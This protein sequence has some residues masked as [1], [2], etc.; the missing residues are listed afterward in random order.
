MHFIVLLCCIDTTLVVI[1]GMIKVHVTDQE[2]SQVDHTMRHLKVVVMTGKTL[3]Y[4]NSSCHYV[5]Q[6][7]ISFHSNHTLSG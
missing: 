1:N 5:M 6:S 4:G 2:E 3:G 7:K